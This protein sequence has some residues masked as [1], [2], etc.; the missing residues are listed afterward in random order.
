MTSPPKQ[1]TVHCPR[2]DERFEDSYRPSINLGLGE[3]WSDE[4]IYDA[5]TAT[6]P[7]CGFVIPLALVVA[8]DVWTTAA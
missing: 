8:D 4:E 3:K 7:T 2:C 5:T 6:C 1:I